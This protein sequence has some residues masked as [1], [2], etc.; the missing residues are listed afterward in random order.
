MWSAT[1]RPLSVRILAATFL[2]CLAIATAGCAGSRP[3]GARQPASVASAAAAWHQV[4]LCGRAHGMPGLQEPRIDAS[5]KAIF[6][7][8][9]NV[10]EQTRRACQTLFDRLVPNAQNQALTPTQLRALLQFARCMRSHGIPDWPD[11]RADGT[12]VPDARI[13]NSL[14]S[15]FRSQLM[16]C[17]HFNPDRHGNVYFGHP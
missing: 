13:S 11:P 8:G 15:A 9:L 4:V 1:A 2:A 5:G 14:K 7:N 10:P 3:T 17:E 6:P 12:F 16:T